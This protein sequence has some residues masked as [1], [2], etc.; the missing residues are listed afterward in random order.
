MTP[1]IGLTSEQSEFYTLA[2]QF[3][4][5]EMKPHAGKLLNL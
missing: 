1:T 4:D 5:N 3:A 2:R